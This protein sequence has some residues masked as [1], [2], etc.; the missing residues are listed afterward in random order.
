M[1]ANPYASQI[2]IIPPTPEN[3]DIIGKRRN[4]HVLAITKSGTMGA[5]MNR[6]EM[7][8]FVNDLID[9]AEKDAGIIRPEEL[10]GATVD[11]DEV[12]AIFNVKD[13]V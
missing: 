5:F 1:T 8:R 10:P 7:L 12:C 11:P 6:A 3:P 4:I 13:L 9:Q 2:L